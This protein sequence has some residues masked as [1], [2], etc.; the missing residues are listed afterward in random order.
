MSKKRCSEACRV[1]K[2]FRRIDSRTKKMQVHG[3]L[4]C[5]VCGKC[6]S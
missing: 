6:E 2:E 4:A 1:S 5:G 3:Q